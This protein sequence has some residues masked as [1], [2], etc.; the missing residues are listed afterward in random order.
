MNPRQHRLLDDAQRLIAALD[1]DARRR[2]RA[3]ARL[4]AHVRKNRKRNPPESGI[5]APAEPPKGPL[6]K[7]G[8][9]EAPLTFD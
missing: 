7:Q 1:D 5:P 9:A 3:A 4:A 8:G 2:R 6:P